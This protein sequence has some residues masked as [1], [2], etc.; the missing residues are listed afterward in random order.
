[1]H[2]RGARGALAASPQL[3][4]LFAPTILQRMA[5][6]VP[7]RASQLVPPTDA[8]LGALASADANSPTSRSRGH[9]GQGRGRGRGRNR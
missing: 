9:G 8:I 6:Q 3:G 7:L 2:G 5:K 1:M 4:V